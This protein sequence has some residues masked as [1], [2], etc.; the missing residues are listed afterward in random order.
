MYCHIYR[1]HFDWLLETDTVAHVNSCFKHA[2]FFGMEFGLV[3]LEDVAPIKGL[4]L[5]FL[6]QAQREIA[7]AE[8]AEDQQQQQQQQ[9]QRKQQQQQQQQQRD[10]ALLRQKQQQTQEQQIRRP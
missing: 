5:H 3:K 4:A 2:L 1:Q 7:E 8:A 6:E 9:Q 10:T